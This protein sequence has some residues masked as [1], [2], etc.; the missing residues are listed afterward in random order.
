MSIQQDQA[1]SFFKGHASEWQRKAAAR[2]YSLIN[3]RHRAVHRTLDQYSV[4]SGLLD[5]GCGAGQL[6]IE[7]ASKGYEAIGIGFAEEMISIAKKKCCRRR[8]P[9]LSSIRV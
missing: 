9:F 5:V 1:K 2:V 8:H 6:A 4:G 7:A 3:D